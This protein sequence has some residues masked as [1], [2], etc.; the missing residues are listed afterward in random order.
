[1]AERDARA[2]AAP[3]AFT[4]I[5][6]WYRAM[7]LTDFPRLKRTKITV[8]TMH[9]F[10]DGDRPPARMVCHP[11]HLNSNATAHQGM[12]GD[13]FWWSH[14]S[15]L[16]RRRTGMLKMLVANNLDAKL[17]ADGYVTT[18]HRSLAE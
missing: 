16:S 14:V 2:M 10:S 13:S 1:M 17:V 8:P 7:P 11:P 3:G 18:E 6:N 4:A 15:D 5:I 9:V 12:S